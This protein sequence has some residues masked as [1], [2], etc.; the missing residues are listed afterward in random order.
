MKPFKPSRFNFSRSSALSLLGLAGVCLMFAGASGAQQAA[1]KRSTPLPRSA[2]DPTLYMVGYSH[3][4]TEWCWNY[5]QVIREFLP[6]TL[7]ENFALFEKYPDYL[8]NWTGSNR[9]KLMKE[10]YPEAYKRLKGYVAA[11]R[12]FPAGSNVEEGDVNSPSEESIVR[13]ILYGNQYFRREFGKSSNEFMIPDCFGFPASLPSIFAHCG[14]KGFSTQKLTWGSA[15]GIPFN[16]GRWE[17][18][19]GQ[20]IVAALN[21][22]S[23]TSDI[24]GDLSHDA[25]WLNRVQ[26]NGQKSGFYADYA[27]YGVGDRGGAPGEDS[28]RHLEESLAGGGPLQIRSA[29]ADEMFAAITPDQ[30]LSLPKYKGDLLLTQHSAGSLT[31]EA[32]M[33]RWNRKN[34]LLADA[35]ERASVAA[36]WLGA[37]PY[38]RARISDAWLRFLPGQFHDL[39]AGTALPQSYVYA[40][41]DQVLA[42]NE[43]AGT[44]QAAV[45]GTARALDTRAQG[46]P[47]LVY[48]P[49]SLARQD[50][51]TAA[52]TFHGSA[53]AAVRVFGP[54]GR[55]VPSQVS[56]RKGNRLDLIFL[57]QVASVGYAVYDVRPASAPAASDP[58][59]KVTKTGLENARYRVRVDANGDISSVYDK[60]AHREL[61][62]APARLAFQYEN[63]RDYPAWNMDWSDQSKPPRA[64]VTGPAAVRIVENGPVR[65]A[66]QVERQARGSRFVQTLR[67]AAGRAGDR[68]EIANK[69]D[70]KSQECA[71]KAVFPL[72]VANPEATYNW[73]LGTVRRGNNSPVKYEVPAHRWFDLTDKRG[74]YGVSVLDDCKYGSDKPD[75]QTVRLTLLYTPGTRGGYQH[76]G[77]Q[78]WGRHEFIYALQGH[79]GSWQRGQTQWEASRLNQPL[80]AFQPSAHSGPLG[81]AFSLLHVSTPQVSVEALKKAEESDEVIVRFNELA[82]QSVSETHLSLA[83]PILAAREVNGQEQPLGGATVQNGQ[84]VFSMTPYRPRAF[85]LRL[86]RAPIHLMP[87][88]G[89]ALAL[90]YNV[91]V[92]RA[93]SSPATSGF[94]GQGNAI[95]AEMLPST[96]NSN[97]VVFQLAAQGTRRSNAVICRGQTLRLPFGMHRQIALLAAS[98]GDD[99][100]AVF[101]MDGNPERVTIQS[102]KG[103]LGQWD[104]RLWGGQVPELT[105][106]WQNPLLGLVPG[107]IKRDPVVWYADH[108][109]LPNGENTLYEF[110]YLYRYTLPVP[111][112]VQVLRLPNNPAVHLVAATVMQNPNAETVPA[113]PL[114]DTLDREDGTTPQVTP[115]SGTYADAIQIRLDPPLYYAGPLHYTLDGTIPG[116]RSPAYSGP[117]WLTKTAT[118][119]AAAPERNG[120]FGPASHIR[121]TVHDTTPPILT[122]ASAVPGGRVMTVRFSEPLDRASAEAADHY[123]LPSGPHAESAALDESGTIVT[124]TLDAPFTGEEAAR[125]QVTGVRDASSNLISPGTSLPVTSV[126]PVFTL[127]EIRSFDGA[128]EGVTQSDVT[129]MPTSGNAPWTLDLSVYTDREP[130]ELTMIGGFGDGRDSAGTQ[131][132]LIK[133]HGGIHFWGSNV[134]ITAGQPFDLGIWQRIT[135]TYNGRLLTIYKN[136]MPIASQT[137]TLSDAASAVRLAPPPAWGD[138]GHRFTGKI[139]GVTLWNQALDA[140]TVR[141]LGKAPAE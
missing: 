70:W 23:Y 97:G 47:V 101:Q 5:P 116:P 128:G 10:Y 110:C 68:L 63:P 139:R 52:L 30:K 118:V 61:L 65:V 109:R 82:G 26:A 137:A 13:H 114:Y 17:G 96:L 27:Y 12:W 56:G 55:E 108:R 84:L 3:L 51:V 20:S 99:V 104:T 103:Y 38:D 60:S 133:L 25:G 62:S 48:N 73:E 140:A 49:L 15:V 132:Y 87:P 130:D 127:A 6:N 33:K 71:L 90:P 98:S 8:F 37:M 58:A 43:F 42:M 54:N 14:L 35:T 7:Y 92:T 95:P 19:D 81:R 11:G 124:L 21:P 102:W 94:D 113:Q 83:A 93:L 66:L 136:G 59:L 41:N 64:Y 131:R 106:D 86:G 74:D 29:R 138:R 69:I 4:D 105:Y 57:A 141:S 1:T 76:Q 34:E 112:G 2:D 40:W 72:T 126:K 125:L 28:V 77:T 75:D 22:G 117:F 46:V 18:P 122:S 31:S 36:D 135:L 100:S 85:A 107:Y 115:A 44:L 16:V 111:D 32:A 123:L 119:R 91:C 9:Y 45:G 67:L 53:P 50:V 79:A 89:T 24:S 78:D 134:D 120:Q 80:L 88:H 129:G 39:M 121:L